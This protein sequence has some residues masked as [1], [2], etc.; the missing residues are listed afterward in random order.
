MAVSTVRRSTGKRWQN[1]SS[2]SNLIQWLARVK[3]QFMVKVY[4]DQSVSTTPP[5]GAI[6]SLAPFGDP[7]THRFQ[8]GG[9]RNKP[10]T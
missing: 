5:S 7:P 8:P 4:G 6:P 1:G 2:A 10:A 9:V 3:R